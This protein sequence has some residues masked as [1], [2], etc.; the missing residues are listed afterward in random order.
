M[1]MHCDSQ[2][3]LDYKSHV[4]MHQGVRTAGVMLV[5]IALCQWLI[6]M[7]GQRW[8][9][10]KRPILQNIG[11]LITLHVSL[12]PQSQGKC[13]IWQYE[14]REQIIL[15]QSALQFL[16]AHISFIVLIFLLLSKKVCWLAVT[17]INQLKAF[18]QYCCLLLKS[19]D[20]YNVRPGSF[21]SPLL[22]VLKPPRSNFL[23]SI[24]VSKG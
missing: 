24:G 1:E 9:I 23:Q 2:G 5:T 3:H 20:K 19:S 10:Q 13:S 8:L 15:K 18:K 17:C 16:T 12:F 4:G 11:V 22:Q 7:P 14:S 6:L 21:W